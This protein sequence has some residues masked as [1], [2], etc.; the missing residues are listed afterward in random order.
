VD[1]PAFDLQSKDVWLVILKFVDVRIRILLPAAVKVR[2][3][4]GFFLLSNRGVTKIQARFAIMG[5]HNSART[6]QQTIF[7]IL[8]FDSWTMRYWI[9]LSKELDAS[10]IFSMKTS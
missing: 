1:C 6:M 3:L 8:A 5:M 9:G 7:W 2:A 10:R 4:L